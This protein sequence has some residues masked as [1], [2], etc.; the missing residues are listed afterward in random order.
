ML[1]QIRAL[2]AAPADRPARVEWGGWQLRRFRD[3]LHLL[4]SRRLAPLDAERIW[5][6][7]GAPPDLG[8]WKLV[9]GDGEPALWLATDAGELRLAPAAGGERLRRNG[10]H[11]RVSELW[12]T[13]AVPPWVRAQWP[14]VYAGDELVSV[15]GVG[16]AD[17]WKDR[18]LAAWHLVRA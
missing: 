13:A 8:A 15:P 12:R 7:G 5:M 1:A 4:E 16:V 17:S 9:P 18:P 3:V 10:C 6:P 2:L 14:L 11:Q